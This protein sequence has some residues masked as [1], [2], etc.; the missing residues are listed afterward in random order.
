MSELE[1]KVK[2]IGFARTSMRTKFE[3]PHQPD[4]DA[5]S[6]V[7]TIELLKGEGYENALRYLSG[8]ERVWLVWWFHRNE[9]W[10]QMVLPPRGPGIRRGVFAT[11]S[12]HRPNP[13]GITCTKLL[14]I[15]DNI[16]EVGELDLID[17]TPILDIKPYIPEVDSFP[18]SSI[19]WLK[20]V[21]SYLLAPP[22]FNMKMTA[23][24]QEQLLWLKE[25]WAEDFYP[26]A[27]ELL[28][29]DPS[30][31]RTRRIRKRKAGGFLIGCGPWR[32]LFTINNKNV[33]IEQVL[34]GYP[35]RLLTE[36][37]YDKVPSRDALLAFIE[38]WPSGKIV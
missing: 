36:P 6:Q 1:L 5:N 30:P 16:I 38:K 17:G 23:L 19:G 12:P 26:R 22:S 14:K 4:A 2:P 9:T 15:S 25:E 10:R 7:N 32:L 18:E 3:A 33:Q 24:A 27:K 8:F 20:E 29:R 21:E 11:R 35:M 34:S 31:H 37:G 28:E 13:I